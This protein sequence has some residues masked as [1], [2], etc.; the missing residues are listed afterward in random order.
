MRL[1]VSSGSAYST[2]F[3]GICVHT[4]FTDSTTSLSTSRANWDNRYWYTSAPPKSNA[5]KEYDDKHNHKNKDTTDGIDNSPFSHPLSP[6]YRVCAA[7]ACSVYSGSLSA[8]H[9]V[10]SR[11]CGHSE[12]YVPARQPIP[13][14]PF[15]V[16]NP[17]TAGS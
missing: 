3:G 4:S 13:S 2:G 12:R 6:S 11:R 15:R 14:V 16:G 1:W 7:A 17:E 9:D 5:S 8:H 10:W